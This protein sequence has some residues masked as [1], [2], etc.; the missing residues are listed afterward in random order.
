MSYGTELAAA[1]CPYCGEPI[2]LV[3]DLLGEE[4]SDGQNYVEDCQVCCRPLHIYAE[5]DPMSGDPS[6]IIRREDD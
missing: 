6:L 5:L 1:D 3:I 2:Q 4:G